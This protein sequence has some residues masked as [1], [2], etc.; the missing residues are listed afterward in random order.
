[1]ILVSSSRSHWYLRRVLD[2]DGTTCWNPL[3]QEPSVSQ[4]ITSVVLAQEGGDDHLQPF[5]LRAIPTTC[6]YA[7]IL[8]FSCWLRVDDVSS[9]ASRARSLYSFT[10]QQLWCLFK[11]LITA[12]PIF[13][14]NEVCCR[15]VER[16]IE[17][18]VEAFGGGA[19]SKWQWARTTLH[20]RFTQVS[21]SRQKEFWRC[22]Q[23][24]GRRAKRTDCRHQVMRN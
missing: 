16:A 2:S 24:Q 17:D 3:V 9:F 1:M 6:F 21:Q 10:V 23:I 13:V 15:L 12:F 14:Q 11:F 8:N 20:A 4:A 7:W 18:T 19:I 5:T 22:W